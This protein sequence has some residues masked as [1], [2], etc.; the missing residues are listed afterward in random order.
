MINETKRREI[1][2]RLRSIEGKELEEYRL[3]PCGA[4]IRWSKYGDRSDDCG[5]E[6]DH[7]VPKA[8]LLSKGATEEEI[9]ESVNLRP[10]QWENNDA[11]NVDY[12]AYH[13]KIKYDGESNK[14]VDGIFEV[15][16]ELQRVLSNRYSKFGV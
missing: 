10:M 3:D 8:F 5:W 1:W 4:L 2:E 11:K 6:V 16:K 9:D 14:R 13:T 7:V 12:P 15:N